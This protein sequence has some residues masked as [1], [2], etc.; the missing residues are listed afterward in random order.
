MSGTLSQPWGMGISQPYLSREMKVTTL[1]VGAFGVQLHLRVLIGDAQRFDGGLTDVAGGAVETDVFAEGFRPELAVPVG[2]VFEIV[3]IGHHD[4]DIF[5]LFH[6]RHLQ[7]RAHEGGVFRGVGI[8]AEIVHVRRPG[9]QADDVDAEHG[10]GRSPTGQSS[11]NL[12]P[13]PSG[14]T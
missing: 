14:S 9:E 2:E 10:R 12:P 5:A 7:H 6:R 3:R 1:V 13:T 8:A 11:E 4:A